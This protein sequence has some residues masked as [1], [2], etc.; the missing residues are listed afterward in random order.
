MD[1]PVYNNSKSS[2]PARSE[3]LAL[4]TLT[5]QLSALRTNSDIPS[6][7]LQIRHGTPNRLKQDTAVEIP[8]GAKRRL[9]ESTLHDR[10]QEQQEPRRYT[11]DDGDLTSP[12][13]EYIKTQIENIKKLMF[14]LERCSSARGA[15]P[16]PP[17]NPY[18]VDDDIYIAWCT[19][20]NV[21]E[22]KRNLF[23]LIER[24]QHDEEMERRTL[25]AA[26]RRVHENDI[27]PCRKHFRAKIN[28]VKQAAFSFYQ[29]R[30]AGYWRP[31]LPVDPSSMDVDVFLVW[32]LQSP[33]YAGCRR[34]NR[35]R[36]RIYETFRY[37]SF[38]AEL[39]CLIATLKARDEDERLYLVQRRMTLK[40]QKL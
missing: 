24:F 4:E 36:S 35:Y 8:R 17:G 18:M 21:V 28:A 9:E 6:N 26:D 13:R 39:G 1:N 38:D 12:R 34:Y 7:T 30:I 27:S 16:I 10:L 14:R 5:N 31:A 23:L 22:Y 33:D 40:R 3:S 25:R 2:S 20:S 15:K 37:N 29:Q 32:C 19:A 11:Q